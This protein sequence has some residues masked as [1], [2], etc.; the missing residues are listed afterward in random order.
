MESLSLKNKIV[1]YLLCAIDI[2]TKYVK[3]LTDKTA[4]A[5]PV[6]KYLNVDIKAL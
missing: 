1:K 3:P 2:F 5:I 4:F 6:K